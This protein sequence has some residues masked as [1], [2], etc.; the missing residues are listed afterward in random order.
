M[1]EAKSKIHTVH[2]GGVPVLSSALSPTLF[3]FD[4]WEDP[5]LLTMKVLGGFIHPLHAC[6]YICCLQELAHCKKRS[7][8]ITDTE[9][10]AELN[11]RV[12]IAIDELREDSDAKIKAYK[13]QL[14]AAY[15]DQVGVGV[16]KVRKN[17]S[18]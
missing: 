10:Q 4:S 18:P 6:I 13:D 12:E 14:E 5:S 9:F 3:A 8:L 15:K 2:T 7:V 17:F 1:I 16:T 11:K